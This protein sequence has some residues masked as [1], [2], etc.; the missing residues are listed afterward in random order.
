MTH[1]TNPER[2]HQ[3]H[4]GALGSPIRLQLAHNPSTGY[5]WHLDALPEGFSVREIHQARK[6][7]S[8]HEA[9]AVGGPSELFEL[10]I[11][12]T[13]ASSG[14]ILLRLRR[15]WDATDCVEE[16]CASLVFFPS[17]DL[18]DRPALRGADTGREPS[19]ADWIL[20]RDAAIA[21]DWTAYKTIA[22]KIGCFSPHMPDAPNPDSSEEGMVH[23]LS[24]E[25]NLSTLQGAVINS[26]DPENLI[27]SLRSF[28]PDSFFQQVIDG[29]LFMGVDEFSPNMDAPLKSSLLRL[30]ANPRGTLD[31]AA[32]CS[33]SGDIESLLILLDSGLDP[34]ATT[35]QTPLPLLYCALSAERAYSMSYKMACAKLLFDHGARLDLAFEPGSVPSSAL[36]LAMAPDMQGSTFYAKSSPLNV[37]EFPWNYFDESGI[38]FVHLLPA[39]DDIAGHQR[40]MDMLSVEFNE[41]ER[42]GMTGQDW[43]RRAENPEFH[44]L[45]R[46]F[47]LTELRLQTPATSATRK[48]P[49][50]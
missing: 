25:A 16:I 5:L 12:A 11:S 19:R 37:F 18:F 10:E 39:A 26:A 17:T 33:R 6:E 43:R 47:E 38:G 45:A 31:P 40:I 35:A 1:K 27:Q 22:R 15:P 7:R 34:N 24:I 20:M 21:Q 29:L 23:L 9:I 3:R 14:E 8:T 41:D 50:L 2:I 32:S 46:A 30:G 44:W 48:G 4:S 36:E 28:V 49:S 13:E 42:P